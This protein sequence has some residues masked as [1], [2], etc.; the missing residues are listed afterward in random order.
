[1]IRDLLIHQKA[2]DCKDTETARNDL[3]EVVNKMLK[4]NKHEIES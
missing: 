2:Q 4:V 1:M 3:N